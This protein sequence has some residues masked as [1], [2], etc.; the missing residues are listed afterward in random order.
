MNPK[1][2]L[3]YDCEW[4]IVQRVFKERGWLLKR[5]GITSLLVFQTKKGFHVMVDIKTKLDQFEILYVQMILMSDS[6]REILNFLRYKKYGD[7]KNFL[8]DSKN[9]LRDYK[10]VSSR[11]RVMKPR[12]AKELLNI[13][14]DKKVKI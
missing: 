11:M 5:L 12:L 4:R 6:N 8:F 9:F 1:I 3:D 14:G 2:K 7:S 13:I 10:I